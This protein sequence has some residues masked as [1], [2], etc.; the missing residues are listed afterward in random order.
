MIRN[1]PYCGRSQDNH[2]RSQAYL[3]FQIYCGACFWASTTDTKFCSFSS[4]L[5]YRRYAKYQ[6]QS[7]DGRY[8]ADYEIRD[9]VSKKKIHE[10]SAGLRHN[11][12]QPNAYS[13]NQKLF[14][15]VL[16]LYSFKIKDRTTRG[17]HMLS[18]IRLKYTNSHST[19]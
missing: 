1:V 17:K 11:V 15:Y 6:S 2:R 12:G 16:L 5:I 19:K 14:I 18:K 13:L 4:M 3:W 10:K 9:R 7:T 8:L